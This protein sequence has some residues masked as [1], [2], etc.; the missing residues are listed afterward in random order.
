MVQYWCKAW[1]YPIWST[2]TK[3]YFWKSEAN[4]E[5]LQKL[6]SHIEVTYKLDLKCVKSLNRAFWV[7]GYWHKARKWHILSTNAKISFLEMEGSLK[8]FHNLSSYLLVTY[9]LIL[10]PGKSLNSIFCVIESWH[11]LKNT[12]IGRQIQ[13]HFPGS[14]RQVLKLCTNVLLRLESAIECFEV[15]QIS[16]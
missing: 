15:F 5:T 14:T 2:S 9:T 7:I 16:K 6:S 11:N 12:K 3:P 1:K 8:T 10:K 13:N 4:L